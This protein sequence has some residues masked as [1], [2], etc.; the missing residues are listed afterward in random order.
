MANVAGQVPATGTADSTQAADGQG[1]GAKEQ[2]GFDVMFPKF[3]DL[4]LRTAC[5]CCSTSMYCL[6]ENYECCGCAMREA[7]CCMNVM[8][9]CRPDMSGNLCAL[10]TTTKLCVLKPLCDD[11]HPEWCT[12][13]GQQDDPSKQGKC[14]TAACCLMG[15]NGDLC[16]LCD[17][18]FI[19]LVT[20]GPPTCVASETQCCCLDMRCAC[21]CDDVVPMEIGCCGLMCV[22][23]TEQL[24]KYH[25]EHKQ[26]S[27]SSSQYTNSYGQA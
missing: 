14:Q 16:F 17:M 26:T 3:A 23:K 20:C 21:P 7:I 27:Y 8:A 25:E 2:A 9:S 6:R 4:S 24:E 12:F 15:C 11:S 10:N 19:E 13:S 1:G 5:C 18:R 22:D